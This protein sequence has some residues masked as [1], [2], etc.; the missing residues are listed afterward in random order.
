[1]HEATRHPTRGNEP[2]QTAWAAFPL[3]ALGASES[4]HERQNPSVDLPSGFWRAPDQCAGERDR[5]AGANRRPMLPVGV[6][7]PLG[8]WR[9]LTRNVRH[10]IDAAEI[11]PRRWH[12]IAVSGSGSSEGD[13][14]SLTFYHRNAHG[15][16][17]GSPWHFIIGNG[18][19]SSDGEIEIGS[20][21]TCQQAAGDGNRFP[22]HDILHIGLVGDFS[23]QQ[24]TESQRVALGELIHYLRAKAGAV[25]ICPV[26]GELDG[27]SQRSIAAC[28]LDITRRNPVP[29][30][31]NVRPRD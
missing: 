20:R 21:W 8:G 5:S 12:G 16:A 19:Q 11:A 23:R 6:D 30:S 9:F 18:T 24:V 14:A 7:C 26:R 15:D 28:P 29:P 13:A 22:A 4:F 31:E 25:P 1:M 27:L 2:A 17:C 10:Q 3:G